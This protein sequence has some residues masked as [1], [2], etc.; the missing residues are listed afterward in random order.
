MASFAAGEWKGVQDTIAGAR[1]GSAVAD[2]GN[3]AK[4]RQRGRYR[5]SAVSVHT[6]GAARGADDDA[7]RNGMRNMGGE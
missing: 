7:R 6:E 2:D 5:L 4:G 1:D 3:V